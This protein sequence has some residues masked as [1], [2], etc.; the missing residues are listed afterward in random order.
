[1][2]TLKDMNATKTIKC[3]KDL[4]GKGKRKA[5]NVIKQPYLVLTDV[6]KFNRKS[7]SLF[8]PKILHW[9]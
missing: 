5:K 7:G 2:F 6:L 8:R 3:Y 4:V 1:M 9:I